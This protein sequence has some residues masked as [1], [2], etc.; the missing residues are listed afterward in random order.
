LLLDKD[1][2]E[3]AAK[4]YRSALNSFEWYRFFIIMAYGVAVATLAWF[5][6]LNLR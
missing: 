6:Q 4:H 5:A 2:E 3:L 1:Y